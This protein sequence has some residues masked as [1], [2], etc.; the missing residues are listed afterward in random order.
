MQKLALQRFNEESN[1]DNVV[2]KTKETY[3]YQVD[4]SKDWAGKCIAAADCK[5]PGYGLRVDSNVCVKCATDGCTECDATGA[6]TACDRRRGLSLVTEGANKVC[7]EC[8]LK[9]Q[10]CMY[11]KDDDNTSCLVCER[12]Y[13]LETN[14][15]SKDVCVKKCKLGFYPKETTTTG[16]ALDFTQSAAK[17]VTCTACSTITNCAECDNTGTKCITCNPGYFAKTDGT[18]GTTCGSASYYGTDGRCRKCPANVATCEVNSTSKKFKV[19][20]CSSDYFIDPT[21]TT[22]VDKDSCGK[23]YFANSTG[24]K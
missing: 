2:D 16:T 22:C 19:L 13:A 18:C 15:S 10:N 14:A 8:T 23:G 20:T 6:C 24:N 9:A 1:L 21:E 7:K 17:I 3:N 5:L 4:A 11:C 12:G